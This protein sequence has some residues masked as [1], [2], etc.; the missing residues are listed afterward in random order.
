LVR[1]RDHGCICAS[2]DYRCHRRTR[3]LD[4]LQYEIWTRIQETADDSE[5]Q[6]KHIRTCDACDRAGWA[7][8]T[9]KPTT[10][11]GA[12]ALFVFA[13][14]DD[15]LPGSDY[16]WHLPAL[17]N[18]SRGAAETGHPDAELFQLGLKILTL[19]NE[20][21]SAGGPFNQVEEAVMWWRREN[22]RPKDPSLGIVWER[23][24]AVVKRECGYE[25]ADARWSKAIAEMY[26]VRLDIAEWV[27]NSVDAILIKTHLLQSYKDDKIISIDFEEKIERSIDR[28]L[29][30]LARVKA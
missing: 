18:A 14:A 30:H 20:A 9:I 4:D 1:A 12:T 26:D 15:G 11:A 16:E 3:R 7:L 29:R 6:E 24:E 21:K 8:T 2:S 22:P 23:R 19:A 25:Q 5:L 10:M 13:P 27:S 17:A 28:D